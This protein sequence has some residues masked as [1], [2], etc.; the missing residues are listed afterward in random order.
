MKVSPLE[1]VKRSSAVGASQAQ[2][3][4]GVYAENWSVELMSMYSETLSILFTHKIL[5]CR[6]PDSYPL[7]NRLDI[8]LLGNQPAQEKNLKILK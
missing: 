1:E 3:K 7:G 6:Q 4:V 5:E 2:A 8:C